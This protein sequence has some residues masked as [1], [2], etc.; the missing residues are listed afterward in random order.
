MY[1]ATRT[2]IALTRILW[3]S[4]VFGLALLILASFLTN[5]VP[6]WMGLVAVVV[7]TCLAPVFIR[8]ILR[9]RNHAA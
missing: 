9:L 2:K 8:I 4:L 6:H 5:S 7:E 1:T 3:G